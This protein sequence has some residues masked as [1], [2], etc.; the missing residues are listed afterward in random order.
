[1]QMPKKNVAVITGGPSSERDISLKSAKTVFNH[2][3]RSQFEPRTILLEGAVFIDELSGETLDLNNFSLS[4]EGILLTFD[5][6]VLMIHG[7]PAE[8]GQLQGY[9]E[10]LGI[11]FTGCTGF[12]SALTFNKQAAK[13]YVSGHIPI[14]RAQLVR[15]GVRADLSSWDFPVFVKPNRNGSSYGASKVEQR[16][17]LPKALDM[18]FEYDDEVLIESFLRGREVTNGVFRHKGEILVLPITEI[19]TENAFFD[20]GAKYLKQSEEITPAPLSDSQTKE[21]KAFSKMLYEL[22]GCQGIVRFDY[23]L[24]DDQFYFLEANTIPG[25]SDESIVP[26]QVQAFGWKLKDF[27]TA[28]IEEA[29]ESHQV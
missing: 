27:F 17:S 11:P 23:M 24:C 7:H 4:L 3:D 26:Q 9:F 10:L 1:M 8:D 19:R 6:I 15:K 25:M 13:A 12:V 18:A 20:Y 14:A 5:V 2:I 29:L 22:L 16:A 28:L 21:C